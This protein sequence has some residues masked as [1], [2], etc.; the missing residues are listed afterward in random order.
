[1]KM[2]TMFLVIFPIEVLVSGQELDMVKRVTIFWLH[3]KNT[4]PEPNIFD[5]SKT[6]LTRDSTR[7]F[8]EST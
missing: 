2:Q 5:T 1:M 8:C 3:P 4:R 7:V 6:G